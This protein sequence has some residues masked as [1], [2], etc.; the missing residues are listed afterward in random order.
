ML[1]PTSK[2][3]VLTAQERKALSVALRT[4]L[5]G[6]GESENSTQK[7]IREKLES[8]LTKLDALDDGSPLAGRVRDD[9]A[10]FPGKR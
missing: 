3:L 7:R 9:S 10:Q 5:R 2:T 8:V 1:Q 6:W 4:S